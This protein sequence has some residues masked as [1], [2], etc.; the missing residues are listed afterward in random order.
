MAARSDEAARRR[1]LGILREPVVGQ[2]SYRLGS[3]VMVATDYERVAKAIDRGR[4]SVV[5]NPDF[6]GNAVYDAGPNRMTISASSASPSLVIH[7]AT[8]AVQDARRMNLTHAEAEMLAYV[9][10]FLYLEKIGSPVVHYMA[11]FTFDLKSFFGW[12]LIGQRAAA[13]A[14]LLHRGKAVPQ[15][16][17]DAI[18]LGFHMANWYREV[19]DAPW[20]FDGIG[21]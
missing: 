8:H 11:S 9:A 14:A 18:R 20:G 19:A 16:E 17:I 2:L 10:Q 13:I 6:K 7:E 4:I 21:D 1:V 3:F 12:N 15:G 5:D